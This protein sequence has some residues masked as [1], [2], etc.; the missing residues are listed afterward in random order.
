MTFEYLLLGLFIVLAVFT[1]YNKRRINELT[2]N[3]RYLVVQSLKMNKI[4]YIKEIN[5]T[6]LEWLHEVSPYRLTTSKIKATRFTYEQAAKI[7]QDL[8]MVVYDIQDGRFVTEH[9][10]ELAVETND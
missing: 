8:G 4:Y 6:A 3:R 7:A 10:E 9:T 2:H 1:T 5:I